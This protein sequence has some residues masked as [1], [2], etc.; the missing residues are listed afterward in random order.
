MKR[1]I[2]TVL[3]LRLHEILNKERM[4]ENGKI[5][6]KEPINF[7]QVNKICHFIKL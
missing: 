3:K 1:A 6:L 2:E 7:F 5:C 4:Y